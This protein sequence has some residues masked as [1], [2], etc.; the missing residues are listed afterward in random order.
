M[1]LFEHYSILSLHILYLS[2]DRELHIPLESPDTVPGDAADPDT[3]PTG[4]GQMAGVLQDLQL[5]VVQPGNS[6]KVILY[7]YTH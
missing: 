2:P 5:V 4:P 7:I 1:Q 6:T 3:A